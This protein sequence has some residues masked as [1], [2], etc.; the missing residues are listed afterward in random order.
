MLIVKI[1]VAPQMTYAKLCD[2]DV[3]MYV[4]DTTYVFVCLCVS[5]CVCVFFVSFCTGTAV[6]IGGCICL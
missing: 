1:P 5:E 4:I 6:A 2:T 3:I